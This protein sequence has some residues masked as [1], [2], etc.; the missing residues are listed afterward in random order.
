MI[1]ILR[2]CKL[3][4]GS[5]PLWN[6]LDRALSKYVPPCKAVSINTMAFAFTFRQISTCPLFQVRSQRLDWLSDTYIAP[7][8]SVVSLS[9]SFRG[10][11]AQ[12]HLASR[13]SIKAQDEQ[14]DEAKA[15]ARLGFG[16]ASSHSLLSCFEL[17][18]EK[19]IMWM[20]SVDLLPERIILLSHHVFPMC[21][22]NN[23]CF[24]RLFCT[25]AQHI[26]V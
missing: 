20:S 15:K 13:A 21:P 10:Q 11:Q 24:Q 14:R 16:L 3:K 25:G 18:W 5:V 26:C 4:T 17:L 6:V 1:V 9:L 8:P 12:A 19:L 2:G 7:F 22:K 23:L